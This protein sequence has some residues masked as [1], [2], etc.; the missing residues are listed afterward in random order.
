MAN[1]VTIQLEMPASLE[2]FTLPPC[3]DQRLQEL[4][5]KQGREGFLMDRER[6]E[7]EGR[8]NLADLLSLLKMKAKSN[9]SVNPVGEDNQVQP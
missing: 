1:Q 4:L 7:T 3:V 2:S 5:D 6:V 8:V 9:Y